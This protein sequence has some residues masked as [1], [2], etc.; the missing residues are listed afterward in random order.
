MITTV[1]VVTRLRLHQEL[2]AAA[3]GSRAGFAVIAISNS[4]AQ[5]SEMLTS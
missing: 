3:V 5:A 1:A 4:E 2:L